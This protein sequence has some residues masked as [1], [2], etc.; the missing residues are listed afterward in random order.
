MRISKRTTI[1]A[2][3]AVVGLAVSGGTAYAAGLIPGADG[4]IHACYNTTNGNVRVVAEGTKCRTHEKTLSWNQTGPVGPQ[5]PAGPQGPV[6][7]QGPQGP[8]GATGPQGPAG[9]QGATGPAGPTGPQGPAGKDAPKTFAGEFK[10]DTLAIWS[11]TA[12]FA[13]TDT[14]A[15]SWRIVIPA[16]TFPTGSGVG[17]GCPIPQVQALVPGGEMVIDQNLCGPLTGDGSVV[18]DVHS[19]DGNEN[20]YVSFVVTAVG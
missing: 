5:G 7:P 8:Q 1:V 14:G 9:P 13:V 3:A 12:N 11:G 19:A 4:T 20:R 15:G 6:G 16:G 10:G 2:V 17:N 18:L